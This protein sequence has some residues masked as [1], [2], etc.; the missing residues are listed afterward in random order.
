LD[1]GLACKDDFDQIFVSCV[2]NCQE[3]DASCIATCTRQ[4]DS[5]IKTCPCEEECPNGCPCPTFQCSAVKN[6][7]ILVLNTYS[8]ENA[9]VII[10]QDVHD[11]YFELGQGTEV[12]ASCSITWQN[13][14]FIFGGDKEKRQIS[15]IKG[16]QLERVSNL[17]LAHTR[18]ACVNVL[19]EMV[20]LC[21]DWNNTKKC[22]KSDHPLGDFE[23]T[24]NTQYRHGY[25]RIATSQ[26][27]N[28]QSVY[29]L[30][31]I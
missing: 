29:Q 14:H 23:P 18:G 12:Y 31:S 9:P 8:H 30:N 21:F 25:T 11:F 15:Q 16:C 4:Y 24:E 5:N 13:Q 2:S 26:S 17:K 7:P 22:L 19:D 1:I 27:K 3:S 20:Y 6:K 10:N 28:M